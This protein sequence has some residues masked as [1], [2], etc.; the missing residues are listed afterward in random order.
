MPAIV[1]DLPGR[2]TRIC[3]GGGHTIA[4][5]G[6]SELWATGWNNKG[7]LGVG[8]ITDSS[9][10]VRVQCSQRFRKVSCG[11]DTSAGIT[12]DGL[13]FVWGSNS[14]CQLGLAKESKVISEP[15]ELQLP[16]FETAVDIQFGLRHSVILTTSGK[17]LVLG[18]NKHFKN[19]EHQVIKHNSTEFLHLQ[20]KSRATQV[21]SGQNHIIV[22]SEDNSLLGFGDNKFGQCSK[23]ESRRKIVKI[24]SG[25]THNAFLTDEQELYLYGRNNYG[26]LCNGTRVNADSSQKCCVSPVEDFELGAE[27]GILKSKGEIFTW[28]WNE[29]GNCGNSSFDDV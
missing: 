22:L 6:N 5:D 13:L 20:L 11:W 18:S 28:G 12:I 27:H 16:A 17:V 21:V 24:A 7:Q 26:Q 14:Q 8:T 10:F 15:T 9:R 2:I 4:L 1:T 29:H 25:W 19:H 23:V 3:G